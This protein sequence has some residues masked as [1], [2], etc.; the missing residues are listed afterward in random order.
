[1][2]SPKYGQGLDLNMAKSRADKANNMAKAH[3]L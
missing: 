2:N 3:G 1:M